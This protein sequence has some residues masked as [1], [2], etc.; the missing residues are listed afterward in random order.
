MHRG[1]INENN[2]T[3]L[4][5]ETFKQLGE[6]DHSARQDFS[7]VLGLFV[8]QLQMESSL[9]GLSFHCVVCEVA[10]MYKSMLIHSLSSLSR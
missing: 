3:S 1:V 9:C 8:H 6:T 5:P 10:D 4:I 2:I 7:D